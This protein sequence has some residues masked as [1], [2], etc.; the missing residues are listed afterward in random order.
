MIRRR[1]FL[2]LSEAQSTGLR[3]RLPAELAARWHC[4]LLIKNLTAYY[5][6]QFCVSFN[7][8]LNRNLQGAY[9]CV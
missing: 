9:K 7:F 1:L 2:H 8:V 3:Q 4:G 5:N 6:I